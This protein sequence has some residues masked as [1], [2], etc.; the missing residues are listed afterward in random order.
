MKQCRFCLENI[1]EFAEACAHCGHWQPSPEEIKSAYQEVATR[2]VR[3]KMIPIKWAPLSFLVVIFILEIFKGALNKPFLYPL[4]LVTQI[5]LFVIALI[6]L[7]SF[8]WNRKRLH[9]QY[10]EKT[11]FEEAIE[12]DKLLYKR[13]MET[14]IRK[15]QPYTRTLLIMVCILILLLVFTNA[16]IW[17][18]L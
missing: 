2:M 16:K 7:A 4:F 13:L 1:H 18:L 5:V 14:Q 3:N 15:S 9:Y 10:L 11:T 8:L 12:V 6:L 17:G